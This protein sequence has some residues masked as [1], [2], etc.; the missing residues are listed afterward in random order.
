MCGCGGGDRGT[1]RGPAG[2]RRHF[3]DANLPPLLQPVHERLADS[4][5][6]IRKVFLFMGILV[7]RPVVLSVP[8]GAINWLFEAGDRQLCA[9]VCPA[10]CRH[11]LKN[12]YGFTLA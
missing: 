10:I 11:L 2:W 12:G 6:V 3:T 1:G 4:V 9:V 5:T 8:S 7:K